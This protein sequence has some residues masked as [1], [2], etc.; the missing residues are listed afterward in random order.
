LTIYVLYYTIDYRLKKYIASCCFTIYR[1]MRMR[2][3]M[4]MRMKGKG[5]GKSV[6]GKIIHI[7]RSFARLRIKCIYPPPPH[8]NLKSKTQFHF[9]SMFNFH[10]NHQTTLP[11]RHRGLPPLLAIAFASLT[12][13]LLLKKKKKKKMMMMMMMMM[14]MVM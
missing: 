10:Q 1:T 11:V 13:P 12:H 8:F 14:S 3:R 5:G 7:D 6:Q 4:R 9:N 2:M